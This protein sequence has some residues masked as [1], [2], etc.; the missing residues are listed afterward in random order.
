MSGSRRRRRGSDEV[1]QLMLRAARELFIER[2]YR[3][4][5]TREIAQLADVTEVLIFSHFESKANLFN[6]AVVSPVEAAID[7]LVQRHEARAADDQFEGSEL[8][9]WARGCLAEIYDSLYGIHRLLGTLLAAQTHD[10]DLAQRLRLMLARLSV[11]VLD[12]APHDVVF[13]ARACVAVELIV[14]S[15]VA[16]AVHGSLLF[17]S[18]PAPDRETLVEHLGAQLRTAGIERSQLAES[19]SF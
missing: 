18:G 10:P 17:G 16:A 4:T 13:D 1:R 2:G 11:M 8:S 6:E 19:S 12:R 14:G 7:G 9:C 5:T 3:G 15:V